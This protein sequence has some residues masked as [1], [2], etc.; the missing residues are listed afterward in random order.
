MAK[1]IQVATPFGAYQVAIRGIHKTCDERVEAIRLSALALS[2]AH[3]SVE[4]QRD[5]ALKGA[6]RTYQAQLKAST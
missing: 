6:W 1:P 5:I 2:D 3:E 4:A